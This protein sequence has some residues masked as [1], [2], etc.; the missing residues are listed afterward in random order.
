MANPDWRASP[1]G[2]A[3]VVKLVVFAV[4]LGLSAV[5]DFV[6][7]PRAAAAVQRDPD[8]AEARRLRRLASMMGRITVLFG[9]TLVALG[10]VL[11]RGW[12]W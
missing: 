11:V 6:L 10:V 9:L 1:F 5:H 12:P 3:V 2:H 7:G 4:V 8:S